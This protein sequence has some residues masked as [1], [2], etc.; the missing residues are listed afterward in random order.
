MDKVDDNYFLNNFNTPLDNHEK[1]RFDQWLQIQNM[2]TGRDV[3]KDMQDYDVQGYW[4]ALT[5]R[6]DNGHGPDTFKK[7]NHPTFSN[8]SIY[9]GTPSPW[10]EPFQ[11][12]TWGDN[13][14]TPS[15]FMMR[16]THN[17][18]NMQLYFKRV[19]PNIKLNLP[20]VTND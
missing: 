10:G 13:E 2:A 4:K 17:P 7:P 1:D 19:E 8:Q 12:G 14:Y 16:H 6:A 18:K 9:H 11:G 20:G 15:D 5:T 3:S